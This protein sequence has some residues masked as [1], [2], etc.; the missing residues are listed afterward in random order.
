MGVWLRCLGGCEISKL[1]DLI[2]RKAYEISFRHV[3]FEELFEWYLDNDP[4]RYGSLKFRKE[5]MA[6]DRNLK[7]ELTLEAES[8]YF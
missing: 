4:E 2:W 3:G 8:G 7:E 6:G 1:D 5:V